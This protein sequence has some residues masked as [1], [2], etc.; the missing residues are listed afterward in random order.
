VVAL[1][2]LAPLDLELDPLALGWPAEGPG[3]ESALRSVRVPPPPGTPGIAGPPPPWRPHAG[4]GQLGRGG[5]GSDTTLLVL[6]QAADLLTTEVALAR[7]G[8]SEGNPLL[9]PRAVRLAVKAGVVA[10]A[11]VACRELRRRNRPRHARAVALVGL[12]VG[13][14]AAV[15][16]VRTLH[17]ARR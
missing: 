6:G 4:T 1:A 12:A 5:A 10:G 9:R 15:H 8:T 3:I 7:P 16:N 13:A 14:A 11:I 2:E 17:G